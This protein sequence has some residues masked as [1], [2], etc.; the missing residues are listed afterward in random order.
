MQESLSSSL[1]EALEKIKES[2]LL[3]T[4]ENLRHLEV[5]KQQEER[6]KSIQDE[7]KHK[8]SKIQQ[9]EEEINRIKKE[10]FRSIKAKPINQK[11]REGGNLKNKS[12]RKSLLEIHL[13]DIKYCSDKWEQYFH[14]YELEIGCYR[15][16]KKIRLLEI[17]VQN[18]GSLQ[19]WS[20]YFGIDSEIVGIDIDSKTSFLEY[21]G[22]IKNYVGDATD[23][24]WLNLFHKKEADFDIIIDDGS[25]VSDDIIKTFVLLFEKIKPGGTYIV[26]DLHACYW[27]SHRGGIPSDTTVTSAITFFKEIIDYINSEHWIGECRYN[28]AREIPLLNQQI[29]QREHLRKL[30][31]SIESIKFSN[32]MVF[33]KRSNSIYSAL[34]KRIVANKRALVNDDPLQFVDS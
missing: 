29:E 31:H 12:P 25:H 10:T 9:L 22:S 30:L 3:K 34:G 14:Q 2:H 17:G 20:E 4:E 7:L 1:L 26:E 8:N 16:T 33:I 19:C 6:I 15:E 21:E 5:A 23:P 27:K 13:Q 32:S 24:D 18:G 28:I 11:T